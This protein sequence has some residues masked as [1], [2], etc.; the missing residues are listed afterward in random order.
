[1][2]HRNIGKVSLVGTLTAGLIFAALTGGCPVAQTPEVPT[3]TNT[4][5]DQ[6]TQTAPDNTP[7][8]IP[9][10]I[11]PVTPPDDGTTTTTAGG[12]NTQPT[13]GDT[14]G[15]TTEPPQ[16][17]LIFLSPVGPGSKLAVR[18][19]TPVNVEFELN[20]SSGALTSLEIVVSRDADG[21]AEADG[22][23]LDSA[24]FSVKMAD[25]KN[26]RNIIA[27]DTQKLADAGVLS[28]Q[29][30]RF[31]F[32]IRTTN[33]AAEV[34]TVFTQG[35]VTVDGVAPT[36]AWVGPTEDNLVSTE[37]PWTVQVRTSDNSPH[38]VKVLLDPDTNPDNGNELELVGETTFVAGT[39]QPRN[40]VDVSLQA[41]PPG[42]YNYLI[43]VS[44][45]IA[46]DTSFYGNNLTAGGFSRIRVTRRLIGE[47]DLDRLTDSNRGFIL[48]GFN[49]ND[50]A[51]SSMAAVPDIDGDGNDELVVVSRFG[52]PFFIEKD[53]VGFGEAYMIYGDSNRLR[54]E[55]QL[56]S[57]GRGGVDGLVFTGI[58]TPNAV[59][60]MPAPN[61]QLSTRWT[62]GLSSVTV[63]PDMDGDDLPEIV[64][65]FPRAESVSLAET[66]TKVQHPD[67]IP[68]IPGMGNLEYD[69]WNPQTQTWT[70]NTAQFT[71]GGIVIVSSHNPLLTNRNTQ[72]RKSD[73]VLDLHET[74]QMFTNM[75]R[76]TAIP[77][78][79][80]AVPQPSAQFV[81]ADCDG[82]PPADAMVDMDGMV[83]CGDDGCPGSDGLGDGVVEDG[84]EQLIERWIVRWDVVL[85]NQG[86]GGFHQPWTSPSA[87]PPLAN[88]AGF[89]FPSNPPAFPFT[90]YPNVWV[91]GSGTG[92]VDACAAGI[93]GNGNNS[94]CEVTNEWFDWSVALGALPC[95]QLAGRPSWST[96]GRPTQTAP[97][98]YPDNFFNDG[99][100]ACGPDPTPCSNPS[101]NA[102]ANGAL[103][104]TGFY[105]PQTTIRDPI[106]ARVL[107]QNVEDQFGTSVASD[108]DFLFISAPRHTALNGD[109]PS[110]PD[111]TGSRT[112]AGAVYQL[113]TNA[114][115]PTRTQLWMERGT[116]DIPGPNPN[117]P[118]TT[119]ALA[120][121]R[122]DSE[123]PGRRDFTMP[124]PHQYIIESVGSLRG[125]PNIA[126]A[127]RAFGGQGQN[128]CPPS[129]DP[130]TNSPDASAC[131][132][133]QPYPVQSSGF[134]VERTPQI[135]G[136]H[137]GA[138][139]SIIRSLDDVNGDGVKDFA[140]GSADVRLNF[141]N[142]NSPVV[143]GVFVVFGRPT[144]TEGDLLLDQ[145]A[146]DPG[147]SQRLR[148][149][150]VHGTASGETLARQIAN[151]HDVNSDGFG[152]VIVGNENKAV[153]GVTNAGE[154]IVLLGSRSLVSPQGGWAPSEIPPGQAIRFVGTQVNQRVGANVSSAGDVDSDGFADF[155]IAA[156]GEDNGRG[157]VYLV[158]GSDALQN[159]PQPIPLSQVATIDLPGVRFVGRSVGDFVG[160]QP[161]DGLNVAQ[162][163]PANSAIQVF[164]QGIATLGDID[165][166]GND[167][168]AI[169]A[170]LADSVQQRDAGEVYILYGR[171]GD[172]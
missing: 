31:L 17:G 131:A 98:C 30:G 54:G 62:H 70:G 34:K 63:I 38:T 49:F 128:Q 58:R 74:G 52:K 73:R 112:L 64:F 161:S 97:A 109:V 85:N 100:P 141:N 80:E 81:C 116:R 117:D 75:N 46:P 163:D 7:N 11:P 14:G 96:A 87:N 90:F 82:A 50:L 144:G 103:A 53:G 106:G 2:L 165:G 153:G 171:R 120:W 149:V 86:P 113:R 23:P 137:A 152:D 29:F 35:T 33:V 61:D 92:I 157:A 134:Y 150:Y 8:E 59:V 160:G 6:Q 16:S 47:F 168:F 56:N 88:A 67:L 9:R 95:T 102:N 170:M 123:L 10:P 139:V 43:V 122:V 125:D 145:L 154:A 143:G 101:I 51:G 68:D 99:S 166:D 91:G 24:T 121:P 39:D 37:T 13:P 57:V 55:N 26:G 60:P 138:K 110:L 119:V 158:Y 104:W 124:V 71:R 84:R 21:D 118:P 169:S 140:V 44:D 83:E 151:G 5:Q 148:G 78:I 167:D 129:Y 15:G 108:G 19:G 4:T 65:G 66:S 42:T 22:D 89:P 36:G 127:N 32:G 93:Q 27:Y 77:Y 1:M 48:Q 18:P 94:L 25:L 72:N 142:P 20:D 147:D 159:L 162:V 172:R 79:R 130:G 105:G 28:N 12:G 132:A 155:L 76:P 146:L 133:Y 45:G 3:S 40:F 156:P 126:L 41:I 107:G 114:G 135:V 115:T 136:P 111:A 69:A 164:S